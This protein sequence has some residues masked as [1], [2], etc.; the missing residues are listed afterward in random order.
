[1][2][3]NSLNDA[4][5]ITAFTSSSNS[6]GKMITFA[7][8]ASPSPDAIWRKTG[9]EHCPAQSRAC[10]RRLCPDETSSRRSSRCFSRALLSAP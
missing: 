9:T 5:S 1:M 7:G 4:N 2:S 6:A 3:L 10:Q 8:G